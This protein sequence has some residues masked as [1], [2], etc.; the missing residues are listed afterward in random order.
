VVPQDLVEAYQWFTV[1][2]RGGP[3]DINSIQGRSSRDRLILKMT[4]AQIAEGEARAKSFVAGTPTSAQVTQPS[5]LRNL[6]LQGISGTPQRRLAIING[7]TFEAGEAGPIKVGGFWVY[8][9]CLNITTNCV[10]VRLKQTGTAMELKLGEQPATQTQLQRQSQPAP[11]KQAA[12]SQHPPQKPVRQKVSPQQLWQVS[13]PLPK[14]PDPAKLLTAMAR[15]AAWIAAC[16]VVI[17]T[18]FI[19]GIVTVVPV[20]LRRLTSPFQSSAQAYRSDPRSPFPTPA[21][22]GLTTK[23]PDSLADLMDQLIKIDWFQFEQVAEIVFRKCGYEVERC[24]GANPDGGVDLFVRKDGQRQAIQCKHWRHSDV[25][26]K[27]VREFLGAMRDA[28]IEKGMFVALGGYTEPARELAAKHG[29][30]LID[31]TRLTAMLKDVDARY[32]PEIIALLDDQRKFC[33]KC[34]NEMEIRT[35]QKG[36]NTGS[37]FWGCTR[38]PRCNFILRS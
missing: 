25:G 34:G 10:Q 36:R 2:G 20:V 26:V 3:W 24:G 32:D 7:Q 29:I 15:K 38:F 1:V 23:R 35:A 31:G 5:Y 27:T 30:E 33:P 9:E 13:T 16:G 28:G 8:L 37:T 18:L 19:V 6:K 22:T 12:T 11:V 4:Q 14:S 21:Q 17:A